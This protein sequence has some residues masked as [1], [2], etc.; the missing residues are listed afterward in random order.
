[1][2]VFLTS[3]RPELCTGVCWGGC[4][5]RRHSGEWR[6]RVSGLVL[7]FQFGYFEVDVLLEGVGVGTGQTAPVDEDGGCAANVEEFAVGLAG[8]DFGGGLRATE[9]GL[10]G[11]GVETRT[12]SEVDHF[13]IGVGGGDDFLIV[14]DQ[15]IHLPEGFG[16]LLVGAASG[17]SSGSSPGMNLVDGKIFEEEF[18]L[19]ILGQ[20]AAH[21]IVE[22]AADGA[23][24]VSVFDE[25]DGSFRVAEYGNAFEV[26]FGDILGERVGGEIVDFPA[27]EIAAIGGEIHFDAVGAVGAFDVDG[28]FGETGRADGLGLADR[29]GE[30][31]A[32]GVVIAEEGFDG[33]LRLPGRSG[34]W[35]LRANGERESG[36]E[37]EGQG[38]K[39]SH[40]RNR[41]SEGSVEILRRAKATLLRMT[42]HF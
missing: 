26:E 13:V 5:Q 9:A 6:S 38:L 37:H 41:G 33:F 35:L 29:D 2:T 15:V 17:K 18:D 12:A 28:N 39:N 32:E 30:L 23:F 27:D 42:R 40:D 16:I 21:G 34:G 8:I 31:G 3:W 7:G 22:I 14:V 36:E 4:C 19:G 10:E 11:V 1:M 20:Q 25:G 24:E